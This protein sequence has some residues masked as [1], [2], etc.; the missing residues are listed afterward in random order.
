[1]S[2]IALATSLA[3]LAATAS[4]PSGA[5]VARLIVLAFVLGVLGW[6]ARRVSLRINPYTPCR[7]CKGQGMQHGTVFR[8]SMRHCGDCRG[9]GHVL[10]AG[11]RDH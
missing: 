3:S 4:N 10:R 7:T 11:A 5:V 9:S 2:G 8:R 1:M 6:F